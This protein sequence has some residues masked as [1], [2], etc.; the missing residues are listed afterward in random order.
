MVKDK[1]GGLKISQG[2]FFICHF[3]ILSVSSWREQ[4]L[5]QPVL[6]RWWMFWKRWQIFLQ[7]QETLHWNSLSKYALHLFFKISSCFLLLSRRRLLAQSFDNIALMEDHYWTSRIFC[8]FQSWWMIAKIVLQDLPIVSTEN[9]F[10]N[11]ATPEMGKFVFPRY[12]VSAIKCSVYTS[13]DRE[14]PSLNAKLWKSL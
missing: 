7:V 9:V 2:I 6:V 3:P 8:I 4:V 13:P 12:L 1:E 14:L 5:S 11:L 10:V